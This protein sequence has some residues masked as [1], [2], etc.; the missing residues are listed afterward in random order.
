MNRRK[1]RKQ[2]TTEN[3]MTERSI[4][5]FLSVFSV[6]SVCSC[7]NSENFSEKH[8]KQDAEKQK[9]LSFLRD[10]SVLCV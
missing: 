5:V 6:A 3:L 10:L 4:P 1:R 7:S 2:R 8:E 9:V